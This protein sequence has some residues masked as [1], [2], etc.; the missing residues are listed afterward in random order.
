[1]DYYVNFSDKKYIKCFELDS[2]SNSQMLRVSDRINKLIY[3]KRERMNIK[4]YGLSS[5]FNLIN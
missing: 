2:I 4:D 5:H 3:I 1:M